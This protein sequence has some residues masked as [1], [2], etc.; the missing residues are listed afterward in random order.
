MI[1][2]SY[3]DFLRIL[4]VPFVLEE[5]K[6]RRGV[7]LYPF[8]IHSTFIVVEESPIFACDTYFLL[9]YYISMVAWHLL[10]IIIFIVCN[11][12]NVCLCLFTWIFFMFFSLLS[13]FLPQKHTKLFMNGKL[14]RETLVGTFDSI[15]DLLPISKFMSFSKYFIVDHWK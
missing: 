9:F 3:N 12:E 7:L 14:K 10:F 6:N 5:E 2:L 8:Y 13:I 1:S 11:V 15:C 4:A